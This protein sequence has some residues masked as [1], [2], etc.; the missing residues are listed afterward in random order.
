K[1]QGINYPVA[2]APDAL[3][4]AFQPGQYIPATIIVDPEGN[5]RDKHVGVMDKTKIERI[6]N[7]FK[8]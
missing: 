2:M 7:E 1:D 6:F 8:K 5:I 4:A 3:V